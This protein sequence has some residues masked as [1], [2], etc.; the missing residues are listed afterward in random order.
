VL[1]PIF[2]AHK[3]A[4]LQNSLFFSLLAGNRGV[5]TGST[6]TASA[7][8]RT[9]KFQ[10]YLAELS[11]WTAMSVFVVTTD[12][13]QFWSKGDA[14]QARLYRAESGGGDKAFFSK[15]PTFALDPRLRLDIIVQWQGDFLGGDRMRALFGTICLLIAATP[16]MA[17]VVAAPAPLLGGGA[18]AIVV[19]SVFLVS[20]LFKRN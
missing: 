10:E 12:K 20:R 9:L 18:A 7:T 1:F 5:E 2:G 14:N 4:I 11:N 6:M 15:R 3:A 13:G 19:G 16:A 8:K 17:N